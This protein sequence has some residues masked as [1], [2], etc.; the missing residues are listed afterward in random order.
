MPDYMIEDKRR[1][2]QMKK[3]LL[4][5][6]LL[7]VMLIAQEAPDNPDKIITEQTKIIKT[8]PN[9]TEAYKKRANAHFTKG[10]YDRAIIDCTE[11]IRLSPADME[12]YVLRGRAYANKG[13]K[14]S[15]KED[16]EKVVPYYKEE[17][18]QHPDKIENYIALGRVYRVLGEYD[19]AISI[20]DGAI[21][22]TSDSIK[23]A[24]LYYI[25]GAAY[26]DK[27]DYTHAFQDFTKAIESDPKLDYPYVSRAV[28]YAINKNYD[29][30]L[31][32]LKQF[33]KLTLDLNIFYPYY[34]LG[35]IYFDKGDNANARKNLLESLKIKPDY[36][37]T[38]DLLK[39]IEGGKKA[40]KNSPPF[41]KNVTS[42]VGVWW[43]SENESI[44]EIREDR[45]SFL[46]MGAAITGVMWYKYERKGQYIYAKLPQG[47]LELKIKDNTIVVEPSL[48]TGLSH[49]TY[50]KTTPELEA[51]YR[52][53]K[54]EAFKKTKE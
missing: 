46:N 52:K 43:C 51:E 2:P 12:L 6:L 8:N 32:D 38:Q 14:N 20:T 11:A 49:G 47:E 13:N 27:K 24:L 31:S 41:E 28:T 30:A 26:M 36:K 19:E 50:Y 17:I 37:P 29:K 45:L 10:D 40:Q 15:G 1:S 35:R 7:P 48:A 39:D 54:E 18:E 44:L 16:C 5:L 22:I 23:L 3:K 42:L 21:E 9:D 33:M 53:I 25:R 4:A 34:L